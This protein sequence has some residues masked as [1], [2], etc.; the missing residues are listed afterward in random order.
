MAKRKLDIDFPDETTIESQIQ[1]IIYEGIKPKESFYGYL[2]NMYL[3]IGLRHLFHDATEIAFTIF[4]TVSILVFLSIGAV[5]KL[6]GNEGSIYT[7]VFISS[8]LLYL[9]MAL[10]SFVNTKFNDTYDLEMTCK[11][12]IYQLAAF[13][14]LVFSIFSIVANTLIVYLVTMIYQQLDFLTAFMISTTSL[15]VFSVMFLYGMI[16]INKPFTKHFLVGGWLSVNLLLMVFSREFY[17]V[18][19]I[20]IPVYVYLAIIVGCIYIYIKNLK[21]L[22]LS[23]NLGGVI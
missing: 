13:R 18:L 22:I 19:L 7:F 14:M 11:Y 4:V 15:F 2:R 21:K 16:K 12:N 6:W 8:P 10:V 3:R 9:A 17:N 23:R 20:N 1:K 5:E